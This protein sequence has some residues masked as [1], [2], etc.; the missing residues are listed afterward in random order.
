MATAAYQH[1]SSTQ[2]LKIKKKTNMNQLWKK[3]CESKKEKKNDGNRKLIFSL[4]LSYKL[5]ILLLCILCVFGFCEWKTYVCVAVAPRQ[6]SHTDDPLAPFSL[7]T[8]F[9][10]QSIWFFFCCWLQ[11][12]NIRFMN[13][14]VPLESHII[15]WEVLL[16]LEDKSLGSSF[17]WIMYVL[18]DS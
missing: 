8:P 3:I 2:K 11:I 17:Q 15:E 10:R 1:G 12:L 14:Q 18:M 4:L 13:V 6:M 16:F 5:Y 7:R 9:M